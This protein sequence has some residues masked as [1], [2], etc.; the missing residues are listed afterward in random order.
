MKSFGSLS[1]ADQGTA[2][3]LMWIAG[4]LI[5]FLIIYFALK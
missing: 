2:K 3:K 1:E 4:G 5:A